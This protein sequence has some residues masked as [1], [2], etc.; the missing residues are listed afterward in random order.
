MNTNIPICLLVQSDTSRS[1]M[2]SVPC[3]FQG[4]GIMR[5]CANLF[6]SD[7]QAHCQCDHV[8]TTPDD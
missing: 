8:Y 1:L 2:T 4:K 3:Y 5:L 6:E 7:N